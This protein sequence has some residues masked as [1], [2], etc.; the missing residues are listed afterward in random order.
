MIGTVFIADVGDGLCMAVRTTTGET[1]LV[2][3][4]S[5]G[6]HRSVSGPEYAFNGLRRIANRLSTPRTLLLSHIHIDHYNGLLHADR[7]RGSRSFLP[8]DIERIISPGIPSFSRA[9]EFLSALLTMNLRL[10]GDKTGIAEYDLIKLVTSLNAGKRPAFRPVYQGDR[11]VIGGCHYTILWPPPVLAEDGSAAKTVTHALE[12]FAITLKKDGATKRWYEY[13]REN[14]LDTGYLE[15]GEHRAPND[16]CSAC[17]FPE[18]QP[19]SLPPVVDATNK[20]LRRAANRLSLSFLEDNADLLFM[21]DLESS[22]IRAVVNSVLNLNRRYFDI[23]VT[24]HHGTHWHR[25]LLNL[26]CGFAISSCGA[27]HYRNL[28]SEY[29]RLSSSHRA[30]QRCGDVVC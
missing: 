16:Q 7:L 26:R 11:V 1:M 30:T 9:K 10:L 24:P 2:D 17:L 19:R 15:S 18:I 4:G 6:G 14:N 3:C 29:G 5:A 13:V 21:G 12:L 25:T 23:F 27:R 8:Q 20:A 28:R 22:D